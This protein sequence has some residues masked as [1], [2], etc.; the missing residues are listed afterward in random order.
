M[1]DCRHGAASERKKEV[2]MTKLL[3]SVAVLVFAGSATYA[4]DLGPEAIQGSMD[5]YKN[6]KLR[7]NR[8]YKGKTIA[9][10]WLFEEVSGKSYS[11]GYRVKFGP[12]GLFS[13]GVVCYVLDQAV[14]NK[15]VEWNKGQ[16]ISVSGTIDDISFGNLELK[17]CQFEELK[18]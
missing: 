5:S 8:D 12:G 18:S 6:N 16:K 15:I 4:A 7:F 14:L 9:F 13:D 1:V 10:S 17:N 11:D 2:L 3:L